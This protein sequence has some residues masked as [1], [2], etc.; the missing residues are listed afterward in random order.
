MKKK[1]LILSIFLLGICLFN[2]TSLASNEIPTET[3]IE[4]NVTTGERKEIEVP[5][6]DTDFVHPGAYKPEGLEDAI[7]L[8]DIYGNDDRYR[9]NSENTSR[10]PY[11]AICRIRFEIQ[12]LNS[13]LVGGSPDIDYAT[14]VMVGKNVVLTAAHVINQPGI[15]TKNYTVSP[16]YCNNNTPFGTSKVI[17]YYL[18]PE[19]EEKSIM[20]TNDDRFEAA[21]YDWAI[22][23]LED[24]LG[25]FSGWMEPVNLASSDLINL[26]AT[27]NGYPKQLGNY[28]YQY[29]SWGQL[30]GIFS[31][32]L[33]YYIDTTGGQSGA[34][35]FNLKN[36]VIGIHGGSLD[37]FDSEGNW[38]DR[39][40]RGARIQNTFYNAIVSVMNKY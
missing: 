4:H 1:V 11:S 7:S 28:Q 14:G 13:V 6:N 9:I 26:T 30:Y 2:Y 25:V 31:R 8:L 37:Y 5:T 36:Q 23:V 19:W 17:Y 32:R 38:I 33:E 35:I 16:G 15:V 20:E 29:E 27:I 3:I 22:L 34:P 10:Y 21:N 24:D 18:P 39:V 12:T 40:N